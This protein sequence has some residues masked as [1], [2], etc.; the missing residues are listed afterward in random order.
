[1]KAIVRIFRKI[2]RP[3]TF[4]IDTIAILVHES[5][6]GGIDEEAQR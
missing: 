5:E 4:V 1:M 6:N 2:A 3:V